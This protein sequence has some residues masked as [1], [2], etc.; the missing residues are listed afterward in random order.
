MARI[1]SDESTLTR[2]RR[3]LEKESR[4]LSVVSR[5]EFVFAG[6]LLLAGGVV[7][8]LSSKSIVLVLGAIALFLAFGHRMSMRED[9]REQGHVAA[10]LRGET[11]ITRLLKTALPDDTYIFNDLNLK[12]GFRKAQID[13]IVV[14]PRGLFVIE[15]KNWRGTIRGRE[16][17]ARWQQIRNPGDQPISVSNPI[18][19]NE[20]HVSVL[21]GVLAKAGIDWTEILSIIVDT[22]PG[23]SFDVPDHTV[24][25]LGPSDLVDYIAGFQPGRPHEPREVDAVAALLMRDA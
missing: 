9:E 21:K 4:V 23:S 3:H 12:H 7:F 19:Q 18:Q 10:G 25:L 24:P 6:V 17:E 15:T 14:S 11:Q 22:S 13:H 16:N 2:K 20:R 5:V 1:L 8:W